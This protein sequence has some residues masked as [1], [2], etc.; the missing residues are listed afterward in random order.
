[1]LMFVVASSFEFGCVGSVI[2]DERG[3]HDADV[4]GNVRILHV[5]TINGRICGDRW[6]IRKV[7]VILFGSHQF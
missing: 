7:S 3:L 4:F 6:L 2:D 5:D 1:M